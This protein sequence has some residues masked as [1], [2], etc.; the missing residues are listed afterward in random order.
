ME[1]EGYDRDTIYLCPHSHYD[2][3]WVFTKE[4]YFYINIDLILKKVVELLEQFDDFK[5]SIEQAFLIEETER[6]FPDLFNKIAEY[7]K[8]GRVEIAGGERLM[9]DTMLT[10][11]ETIIREIL[12]GK[13]YVKEKFGVEVPVM[14]QADSFGLNAQLP[15]IYKKSG[16]KWVAFRRGC[17][18][19]KPSE[20]LWEGLDGT[21]ILTHWMPLGYRA[22]LDLTKLEENYRTL[23]NLSYSNNILMPSGSGVTMPQKT[24]SEVV[25]KWNEKNRA[26][27]VI[28]TPSEF[29]KALEAT[30]SKSDGLTVRKGE[31]YSGKYS[32]VFSDC[33]SSRIWLKKNL[34]RFENWVLNLERFVAILKTLNND[35]FSGR[36][37]EEL[38]D[39]WKKVLFMGFHD[40]I[41]GT[42]MD[43]AYDEVRDYIAFLKTKMS[44]IHPKVLTEVLEEDAFSCM[45]DG[46]CES[47]GDIAVFNPLS[48]KVSNWVEVD[49]NFNEGVVKKIGGLISDDEEINIEVIR[50]TRYEDE[51]LRYARI[52]FV[53]NVP[54]MGY[55]V[56]RIIHRKPRKKTDNFIKI[57]G[58]VIETKDH[59][60][61]FEP[62]NGLVDI[63]KGNKRVCT[64][65]ELVLEEEIGDL[66]YHKETIGFPLKTEGGE[67]V[68]YGSF[69]IKNFWIEKSPL[70]RVI[71]IE[72][73]YFS[74]RWPYRLTDKLKPMIWRHNYLRVKKKIIVYRDLPRI[75]F[76]TTVKNHHPRIRL[77][78]KFSS[79]IKVQEYFCESQF[80]VVSRPAN[81]Y[82]FEPGGWKEKPSGVSPSLRWVD[83]SDGNIGMTLLNNGN[84]ENEVR[85]G[86]L[87]IT[88]LRGVEMLSSDGKA[89]PVVPVPDAR[90]TKVYT[91]K[92][93]LYP[94]E[95]DW[96]RGKSYQ[97]GFEFNYN[98]VAMQLPRNKKFR[99]IRSFLEI[100]PKNLIM[101][102]LKPAWDS[103]GIILRFYEASGEE[104]D[105]KINLF[106]EPRKVFR[107]NLI[108]EP[109]EEMDFKGSQIDV[110]LKPFE[111]ETLKIIF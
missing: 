96:R 63:F 57:R 48:W 52:G 109:L 14:W 26:K 49:L 45:C 17:P 98:L 6:R 73:D 19:N 50:F 35:N 2:A 68:K 67:G 4:D 80:G 100:T 76:I 99:S 90:E 71:H 59:S 110:S 75:D 5:F 91:F 34:R 103:S 51:S 55:K 66:Y 93:S 101:T 20:F 77:R 86:N 41:P 12:F 42:G 39:F 43:S 64:A 46:V 54:A 32:E 65:N 69:R 70:R 40:V 38:D 72:T 33:A 30:T 102:S 111:I 108:E 79:D 84:P 36:Y 107:V 106:K 1:E 78:V 31:M 81:Q 56:Y 16:Y 87:Y 60:V 18:E 74:L 62:D 105:G 89:G 85:D 58:N 23:R 21:R 47:Y 37:I 10:Q 95:G 27:M 15:Q 28:S 13:K 3:V 11:E 25:R 92:Y 82:Y 61:S 53:A 83:Y 22:G 8:E 29:F 97:Q 24:T 88:L 7:I 104:T 94:H 9:A 44:Y